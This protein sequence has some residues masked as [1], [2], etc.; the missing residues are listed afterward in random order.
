[1]ERLIN[2]VC[3]KCVSASGGSKRNPLFLKS[4]EG[5]TSFPAKSFTLI[6]LLVV[7]AIIAILAAILLPT[8]QSARQL[9]FAASCLSNQKQLYA[10]WTQYSSDNDDQLL[11]SYI[12]NRKLP[13]T[14]NEIIA[15]ISNNGSVVSNTTDDPGWL[16][17][18]IL[19]NCPA[20]R[21]SSPKLE[22]MQKVVGQT[23]RNRALVYASIGYN[24]LF[25]YV[26]TFGEGPKTTEGYI[27]KLSQL[28][29]NIA[30]TVVFGDTWRVAA[31]NQAA[32]TGTT[33]IQRFQSPQQLSTGK[34]KAHSGGFNGVYADGSGRME[35]QAAG[36]TS[37]TVC[38]WDTADTLVWVTR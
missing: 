4:E 14:S 28:R 12:N 1:M 38:V 24:Q 34:L 9:G 25:N 37:S 17:H 2:A 21:T 30:Q 27:V 15:C 19:F 3:Q 11:P 13:E 33:G 16:K 32:G 22:V 26:A 29:R 31:Y 8:L 10:F 18:S 6:E 20:D 7:I 23:H 5:K 35:N 36:K